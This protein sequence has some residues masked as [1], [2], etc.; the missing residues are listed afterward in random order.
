LFAWIAKIRSM[1]RRR[2]GVVMDEEYVQEHMLIGRIVAPVERASPTHS[3]PL[4]I[5]N[6]DVVI[7]VDGT[8]KAALEEL[9]KGAKEY[10]DNMTRVCTGD[11][12]TD[13]PA[14]LAAADKRLD[15]GLS[16]IR[17]LTPLAEKFYA[18]LNDDQKA[19]TNVFADWPGLWHPVCFSNRA[20]SAPAMQLIPVCVPN[21]H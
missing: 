6:L 16:G 4:S 2:C 19:Q 21:R 20:V 10:S 9:K 18:A 7:K 5:A 17:K 13:V 12:P 11:S 15:A 1:L 3:W 8:Q 14:K